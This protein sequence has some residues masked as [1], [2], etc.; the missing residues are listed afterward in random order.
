MDHRV[1]APA[2]IQAF[3]EAFG[4]REY[5]LGAV[6]LDQVL[7]VI[8]IGIADGNGNLVA[9]SAI[10]PYSLTALR[11]ARAQTGRYFSISSVSQNFL[12]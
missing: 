3:L 8:A 5:I 6:G 2:S 4:H 10:K 9:I 7:A 1:G 11:N 12:K